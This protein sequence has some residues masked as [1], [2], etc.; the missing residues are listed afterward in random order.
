MKFTQL[1]DGLRV[2]VVRVMS[3]A[4]AVCTQWNA[5]SNLG[6]QIRYSAFSSDHLRNAHDFRGWVCVMEVYDSWIR[7]VTIN[8][9]NPRLHSMKPSLTSTS[10]GQ[11]SCGK[12]FSIYRSV[13][14]VISTLFNW[15]C[16][17][18][19]TTPSPSISFLD[20]QFGFILGVI[21]SHVRPA[22]SPPLRF[23]PTFLFVTV[24][25]TQLWTSF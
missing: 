2:L 15:V 5:L 20:K 9:V 21:T 22:C 24:V 25:V 10:F 3:L 8:A 23:G 12:R 7:C 16:G 19:T 18:I 11:T 1:A 13:S 14:L 6:Q 17:L 4:M